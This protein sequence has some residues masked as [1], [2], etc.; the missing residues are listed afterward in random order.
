MCLIA[1]GKGKAAPDKGGE[2]GRM[3]LQATPRVHNTELM[4]SRES[5]RAGPSMWPMPGAREHLTA[6]CSFT[7]K[8]SKERFGLECMEVLQIVLEVKELLLS[9]FIV[10]CLYA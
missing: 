7:L 8:K 9:Y 3:A 6:P 4:S 2:T 1:E 5:Q 10:R